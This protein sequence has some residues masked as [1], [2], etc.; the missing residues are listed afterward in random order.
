MRDA[1]ETVA[2]RVEAGD[3]EW[4]PATVVAAVPTVVEAR[5]ATLIACPMPT[6]ART[7]IVAVSF[8]AREAA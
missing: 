3:R 1:A 2:D 8:R 7:L 4:E 5:E 6:N